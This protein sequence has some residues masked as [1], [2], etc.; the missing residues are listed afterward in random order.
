MI[1][2]VV[3][4]TSTDLSLNDVVMPK[5]YT[6]ALWVYD[7]PIAD[8]EKSFLDFVQNFCPSALGQI[9]YDE[10]KPN[11]GR[12]VEST[13]PANR[14]FSRGEHQ[15]IPVSHF[16]QCSFQELD[17]FPYSA[18]PTDDSPLLF[19]HQISVRDGTLLAFGIHHWLSDGHGFFTLI[20]RFSRWV[21][22]RDPSAIPPLVH[23]RSLLKPAKEIRYPHVEYSTTPP[24]FPFSTMPA[25]D[26][27]V[28]RVTKRSLFEHL[29]ISSKTVSFND[30]LVAWLTQSISRI[31][32][33]PGDQ[34]VNAGIASDARAELGL[35]PDYFGNCNFYLCLQ[36]PMTDLI[37]KSVNDL[38]EQVN[39][40][41]KE[42]M[43][44]EYITSAMAW[45]QAASKPIHPGF[46]AFCGQDV[47]FTNWS[48]FPA[49]QIDFGR[50]GAKRLALP[51][52][53]F[54]GLVL[55]FPTDSEAVELYIGL[56]AE[57]A[58]KLRQSLSSFE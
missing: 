25:M 32:Q 36:F 39:V 28:R 4:M 21:R 15:D 9:V 42:R 56:K 19:L 51:P 58:E 23:D 13:R 30:V 48:R 7:Y 44:K 37:E 57:H 45:I 54:D 22:L 40:Q 50:G 6:R 10:T 20:E 16:I 53:R 31:R 24:V 43:T 27:L 17:V 33:V 29:K 41:K 35:G 5:C 26:V 3:K 14:I 52:A 38:A 2:Q 12:L 8:L 49:F 18:L 11:A 47:A 1:G 46:R 55:I 34:I